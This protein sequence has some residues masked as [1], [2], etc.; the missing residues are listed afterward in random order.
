MNRIQ[1]CESP[2]VYEALEATRVYALHLCGFGLW[3][4]CVSCQRRRSSA[5][6]RHEHLL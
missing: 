4:Y 3:L 6:Q 5:V 2:L 1:D